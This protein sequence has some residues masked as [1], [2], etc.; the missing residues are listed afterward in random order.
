MPKEITWA[1]MHENHGT[2]NLSSL[3]LASCFGLRAGLELLLLSSSLRE[4]I[5]VDPHS[6]AEQIQTARKYLGED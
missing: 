4:K 1:V 3:R 6:S 2:E 5:E